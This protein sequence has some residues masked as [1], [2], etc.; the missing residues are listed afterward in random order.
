L[1]GMKNC[2]S[3]WCRIDVPVP[4][5]ALGGTGEAPQQINGNRG[6]F[7]LRPLVNGQ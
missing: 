6:T 1:L 3:V 5:N 2:S 7:I 4:S